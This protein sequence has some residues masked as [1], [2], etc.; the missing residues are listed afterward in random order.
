MAIGISL[1]VFR[2][3]SYAFKRQTQVPL[4]GSA[5][6]G[7]CPI[8]GYIGGE[9]LGASSRVIGGLEAEWCMFGSPPSSSS[10][11][12]SFSSSTRYR[13]TS[14]PAETAKISIF[15]FVQ[16]T[17]AGK[18]QTLRGWSFPSPSPSLSSLFNLILDPTC[19]CFDRLRHRFFFFPCHFFK[20][21]RGQK[22]FVW[23]G[24][25]KTHDFPFSRHAMLSELLSC[26]NF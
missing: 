11:S 26:I 9:R 6:G 23:V 3:F 20:S 8:R 17:A 5:R 18:I 16:T 4:N 15:T 21:A 1:S 22:L 2:I 7:R 25:L 13:L 10:S 14:P 24:T 12:S 19:Y